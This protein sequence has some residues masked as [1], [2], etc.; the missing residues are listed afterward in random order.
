MFS[1]FDQIPDDLHDNA[2][3]LGCLSFFVAFM[4]LFDLADPMARHT[5]D[6]TQT[7][8]PSDTTHHQEIKVLNKD[9]NVP[10]TADA[11]IHSNEISAQELNT[12]NGNYT[13]GDEVDFV[14]SKVLPTAQQPVFEKVLLPEKLRPHRKNVQDPKSNVS[15]LEFTNKGFS[16]EQ[17]TVQSNR[18]Q[19]YIPPVPSN[20]QQQYVPPV[21]QRNFDRYDYRLNQDYSRQSTYNL[22]R[23]PQHAQQSSYRQ[24]SCRRK[25]SCS[26]GEEN[27]GTTPVQ[28]GFVAHAARI[29]DNRAKQTSEF[30]TIV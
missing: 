30:N 12:N 13:R 6:T 26:S 1:A 18:Q 3:I 2:I 8:F 22:S 28:P 11:H 14:Q 7:D 4:M 19:Q 25:G 10:A 29:W 17:P 9:L 15:K 20:R 5:T 16:N 21:P 27:F 24:Q 23:N